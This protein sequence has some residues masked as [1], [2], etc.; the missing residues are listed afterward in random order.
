MTIN[1]LLSQVTTHLDTAHDDIVTHPQVAGSYVN[2]AITYAISQWS[3][4]FQDRLG[5]LERGEYQNPD[6]VLKELTG[7]TTGLLIMLEALSSD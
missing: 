6:L 4:R 7:E 5:A 2:P 3:G 1:D